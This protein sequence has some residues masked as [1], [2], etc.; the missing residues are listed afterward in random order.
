MSSVSWK[1]NNVTTAKSVKCADWIAAVVEQQIFWMW[2]GLTA[3][4]NQQILQEQTSTTTNKLIHSS[5]LYW[6][7]SCRLSF[8]KFV[9]CCNIDAEMLFT[10]LLSVHLSDSF[11]AASTVKAKSSGGLLWT[12]VNSCSNRCS[13]HRP[14]ANWSHKF[15]V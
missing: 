2:P 13:S 4:L 3:F 11:S 10:K 12:W 5:W 1:G 7:F 15:S 8:G 9:H 6:L 14:N